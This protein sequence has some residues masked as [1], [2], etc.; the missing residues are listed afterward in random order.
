MTLH[1]EAKAILDVMNQ[2]EVPDFTQMEAHEA[3][4]LMATLRQ[5]AAP[6]PPLSRHENISVSS[7]DGTHQIAGRVYAPENAAHGLPLIVYYHGGGWVFGDLEGHDAFCANLCIGANAVV[8]SVDYRLAPEAKFPVPVEDCYDVTKWAFDNAAS[9]GADASKLAVGGDSAGGNLAACVALMAREADDLSI[10][11]QILYYPVVS[12]DFERAS[13]IDNAEGYFLTRNAMQWFWDQY[14]AMDDQ[15]RDPRVAPMN[16]PLHGLPPALVIT[17]EYDP[18]RDEGE[19]Y[20][21][22]LVEA[23]VP[24][25]FERFNGQIHGFV[26]MIDVLSDAKRV[27]AKTDAFLKGAFV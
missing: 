16:A 18:L 25:T 24:T 15:A 19:H 10:A 6:L 22:A 7:R 21:K 20:A 2:F 1:P 17:A 23:Q 11:A 13:Y 14:L 27:V 12:A 26:S 5:P 8:V 4:A 3:R 9:L